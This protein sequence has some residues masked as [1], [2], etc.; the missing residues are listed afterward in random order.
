MNA[1]IAKAE[2]HIQRANDLLE[3]AFGAPK[4]KWKCADERKGSKAKVVGTK[5]SLEEAIQNYRYLVDTYR[6]GYQPPQWVLDN[7]QKLLKQYGKHAF[8]LYP[9]GELA[10]A[11]RLATERE[12]VNIGMNRW[13]DQSTLHKNFGYE[14]GAYQDLTE[15]LTKLPPQIAVGCIVPVEKEYR[16]KRSK[17][18]KDI[19]VVNV[20]GFAFDN[21]AQPDL[22][23]L[24]KNG[25][26]SLDKD[27]LL[28][29]MTNVYKLAF[30]ALKHM[31][32]TTL[33][34]SP[35]GNGSF[36]PKLYK[37]SQDGFIRDIVKPAVKAAFDEV[38]DGTIKWKWAEY[39]DFFVPH[40]FFDHSEW[41]EDLD[42][43]VY[44]NAWDCWSMLGNGNHLD[45]S[46][47]GWWGRSSA[48]SLVGWPLSNP[49]IEFVA[50]SNLIDLNNGVKKPSG[51]RQPKK[52][53]KGPSGSK[54]NG[55]KELPSALEK[56]MYYLSKLQEGIIRGYAGL[57]KYAGDLPLWVPHE[58]IAIALGHGTDGIKMA[59]TDHG[60]YVW[61]TEFENV[62]DTWNYEEPKITIDGATYDDA[63]QY[64]HS[65]KPSPF[66]KKKWNKQRLKVMKDAVTKKLEADKD[67]QELLD[68]TGDHKLVSI[69]PDPFWG[70]D[71]EDGGENKL[72]E[73]WEDLRKDLQQK[74]EIAFEQHVDFNTAPRNKSMYHITYHKIR[75]LK[76]L[77]PTDFANYEEISSWI[78][79]DL[80][81][82]TQ[83]TTLDKY[84]QLTQVMTFAWA[85]EFSLDFPGVLKRFTVDDQKYTT[86]ETYYTECIRGSKLN[87]KD[88]KTKME[89]AVRAFIGANENVGELLRSTSPRE[90]IYFT[91]N[92]ENWGVDWYATDFKTFN[93]NWLGQIYSEI[94]SELTKMQ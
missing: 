63:E 38:N 94:R 92:H 17:A 64:Y 74:Q 36:I 14:Q 15:G 50:V 70:V 88:K 2:K 87:N 85:F 68:A 57:K 20:I 51:K 67:L 71:P 62:H 65:R 34:V 82:K 56:P 18:H 86:M 90:L 69:K 1:N 29:G 5:V 54:H 60:K 35:V 83:S 59:E 44:M 28:A 77:Y 11:E 9:K 22:Q 73:I 78:P 31:K 39:D 79:Y 53:S 40:S 52:M 55:L 47:D 12:P 66:N 13:Y 45:G 32:R 58:E 24:Q 16:L 7:S 3:L 33:C 21:P 42:D 75:S 27:R 30:A 37:T 89:K 49:Y 76:T 61:A 80:F 23:M 26:E 10:E 8:V 48:V 93:Q 81:A 46:L 91:Q 25:P 4:S 43:R 19:A 84:F 6:K 72:A 41:S